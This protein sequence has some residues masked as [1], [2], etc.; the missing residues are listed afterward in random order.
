MSDTGD[1]KARDWSVH[2][3]YLLESYKSTVLRS[4]TKPLVPLAQTLSELTGP[5][6]G[7][8]ELGPLDDDLTR[9]GAVDGEPQGERIIITGRVLD[10]DG[11]PVPNTLIEVWQTNAAGR[12]NHKIDQHDAPI[13]PAHVMP[14]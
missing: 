5:V 10:E 8:D 3:P 6:Y 1:F 9:N 7:H 13:D 12:Y 14:P 4:P 11:R 2:P